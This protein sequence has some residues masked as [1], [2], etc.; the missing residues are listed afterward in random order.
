MS[1]G[2][3]ELASK[4]DRWEAEDREEMAESIDE[5][6]GMARGV[7]RSPGADSTELTDDEDTERSGSD[8]PGGLA[9][10]PP[11]CLASISTW[12]GLVISG[13]WDI[14]RA[15]LEGG[16]GNGALAIRDVGDRVWE[17][18]GLALDFGDSGLPETG[19]SSSR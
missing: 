13:D 2:L 8:A 4:A 10:F 6:R 12:S 11:P 15:E 18:D 3:K 7:G 9:M 16:V 14:R 5:V 17:A 19:D 1:A